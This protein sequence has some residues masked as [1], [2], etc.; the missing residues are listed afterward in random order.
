M[1]F[2][3]RRARGTWGTRADAWTPGVIATA[4]RLKGGQAYVVML[5]AADLR[6]VR[7]K[8]NAHLL[9]EIVV[10]QP[11]LTRKPFGGCGLF[12]TE[13]ERTGRRRAAQAVLATFELARWPREDVKWFEDFEPCA[14]APAG[15]VRAQ[16]SRDGS[17]ERVHGV[18]HRVLAATTRSIVEHVENQVHV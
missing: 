10:I 3:A 6:A 1:K 13:F 9:D 17:A 5:T 12:E 4:R 11:Y 15:R 14:N 8:H 7:E 16:K 2:L 18:L